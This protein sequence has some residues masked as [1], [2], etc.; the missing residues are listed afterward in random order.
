MT[1]AH[2]AASG[3]PNESAAARNVPHQMSNSN[4]SNNFNLPHSTHFPQ[5]SQQN[6]LQQQHSDRVNFSNSQ[7]EYAIK[8]FE[9]LKEQFSLHQLITKKLKDSQAFPDNS[10]SHSM[11]IEFK[12]SFSKLYQIFNLSQKIVTQLP[13]SNLRALFTEALK[14]AKP[15]MPDSGISNADEL[16]HHSQASNTS[17][18]HNPI[19]AQKVDIFIQ[20]L[21]MLKES[22]RLQEQAM[23]KRN[24]KDKNKRKQV[25]AITAKLEILDMHTIKLNCIYESIRQNKPINHKALAQLLDSLDQTIQNQ[26]NLSFYDP[27]DKLY[28]AIA[29]SEPNISMST[30]NYTQNDQFYAQKSLN[31]PQIDFENKSS[32]SKDQPINRTD[33]FPNNFSEM[34]PQTHSRNPMQSNSATSSQFKH[35]SAPTH[36]QNNSDTLSS[37]GPIGNSN[38][39]K[40]TN[41]AS[42]QM[43]Q[44]SSSNNFPSHPKMSSNSALNAHPQFSSHTQNL[45]ANSGNNY[46][47]NINNSVS[48]SINKNTTSSSA[49]IQANS[50]HHQ[51]AVPTTN[52]TTVPKPLTYTQPISSSPPNF[53]GASNYPSNNSHYQSFLK[54]PARMNA[55]NHSM[56]MPQID[57]DFFMP[58]SFAPSM[59]SHQLTQQQKLEQERQQM[60]M[61]LNMVT[62]QLET[63]KDVM[64]S[65]YDSS[66]LYRHYFID[67]NFTNTPDYYPKVSRLQ[68]FTLERFQ[69]FDTELLFMLFY[70][71][72][73]TLAQKLAAKSLKSQSWRF[74]TQYKTWFQRFKEP[75]EMD[76]HH[77]LGS[78]IFFDYEKWAQNKQEDFIFEYSQLEDKNF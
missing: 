26:S 4:N 41:S 1:T 60:I 5:N 35:P 43:S 63:T 48:N 29:E 56:N 17:H 38:H 57:K 7:S 70:R 10:Q 71:C 55:D 74:H 21:T 31:I 62:M 2:S 72:Q 76:E 23:L 42:N 33:N 66:N 46:N 9:A 45:S 28:A 36:T 37:I 32:S 67:K 12:K 78:Y 49:K 75:S 39:F 52:S 65:I 18:Q 6:Q 20:Q 40:F 54:Q 77:E 13:A 19:D 59:S 22:I 8:L 16:S 51:S 47:N 68:L 3:G 27:C 15:F 34:Q 73:G 61:E 50:A 25:E 69:N 58:N 53:M 11:Q 30:S 44:N 14:Q 64:P 24:S